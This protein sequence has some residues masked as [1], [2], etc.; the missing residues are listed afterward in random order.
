[1][2]LASNDATY[3]SGAVLPVTGGTPFL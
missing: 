1:V 3:I 2:F